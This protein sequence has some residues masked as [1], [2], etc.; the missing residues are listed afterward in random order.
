MCEARLRIRE[1]VRVRWRVLLAGLEFGVGVEPP[2][3][4]GLIEVQLLL[5]ILAWG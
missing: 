5:R 3:S 4:R 2:V 1:R